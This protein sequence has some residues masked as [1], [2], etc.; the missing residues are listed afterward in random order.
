MVGRVRDFIDSRL[1]SRRGQA[2]WRLLAEVHPRTVL[3]ICQGNICRSPFAAAL[4]AQLLPAPFA[5][6]IATLSAG[7]VGPDRPS[8][9]L[10]VATAQTFDI[11][12]T[13]HRSVMVTSENLR[14]SDLVVV[15]SRAQQRGISSRVG[16]SVPVLVLGDLDPLPI[17]ERT[18]VDPW[19]GELAVFEESYQRIDRC[20]RELVHIIS[21]GVGPASSQPTRQPAPR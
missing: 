4:F 3:F 16:P 8:P 2:A 20:V 12:L 11:D 18:I 13:A 19:S 1:H 14:G 10:A 5:A 15:M 9:P 7:F 6:T 21:G 17:E